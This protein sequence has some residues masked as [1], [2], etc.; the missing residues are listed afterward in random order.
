MHNMIKIFNILITVTITSKVSR[1]TPVD[2]IVI[3]WNY[4]IINQYFEDFFKT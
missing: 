2:G 4:E 1:I 3:F